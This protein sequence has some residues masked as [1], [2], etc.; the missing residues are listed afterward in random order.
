MSDV[1]ARRLSRLQAINLDPHAQ[2]LTIARCAEDILYWVNEFCWTYDPRENPSTL[3]FLLF[4]RQE[5]FLT[6]LAERERNQE[7]GV[8]VKCRDVGFTWL[9]ATYAL[10]GWLYRDGFRCGFGSRKLE[11]VDTL[12]D[13][14]CIFEKMRFQLRNQPWW[15]LPPGFNFR[16]HDNYCKLLNPAT[17]A[18]I[19]GEGGDDIG[20]GDRAGLYFVD[21]AAHLEHPQRVDAA[22]SQTTRCRIDVSTPNGPG[23]P[24]ATK[25]QGGK[26]PVFAF[27]WQDDPRKDQAWYDYQASILD[28][29]ILAQEVDM[30]FN[31][32]IEGVTIEAR[33]VMAAVEWTPPDEFCADGPLIAGA[34]IAG[35]GTNKSAFLTRRGPV[36]KGIEEWAHLG[37]TQTGHRLIDLATEQNVQT[38]NFDLSG[39]GISV[40][41]LFQTTERRLPFQYAGINGG[42]SP[43]DDVWPDGRTSKEI[44]LNLRAELYWKLRRRFEKTYEFVRQGIPHPPEELISIPNHPGLIA[45]LSMPLTQKTATGKLKIESKEDMRARGIQSPDHA[46]ALVYSEAGPQGDWGDAAMPEERMAEVEYEAMRGSRLW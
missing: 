33:W 10:H 13:P 7:N 39:L 24:F 12:G 28:A 29:V 41:E 1:I 40:Q 5:E 16:K 25:C 43:S 6:W 21:E 35:G 27:R 14:K 18:T 32:S 11:L 30:D 9:C 3:P 4:P 8:A 19:S 34:D 17:G 42:A 36:V 45:E 46:D 31:A 23:N 15:M 26:F 37:P 2:A 44:F 22:L 38:L 20:R